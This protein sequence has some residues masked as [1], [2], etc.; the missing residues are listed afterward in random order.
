M[1]TRLANGACWGWELAAAVAGRV[2]SHTGGCCSATSCPS[3]PR[4][5]PPG[6]APACRMQV[7]RECQPL[8]DICEFLAADSVEAF[9]LSYTTLLTSSSGVTPTLLAS[10]LYARAASDKEMTKADVREV[11]EQCREVFADRQSR[12][13]R[14]AREANPAAVA[15]AAVAAAAAAKGGRAPTAKETAFRAAVNA[16]RKRQADTPWGATTSPAPSSR[17]PIV[18]STSP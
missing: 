12:M 1:S 17:Q 6:F 9:V 8:T 13:E 11:L 5:V 15:S 16:A 14:E 2:P 18:P 7:A 3:P 10:L 4:P